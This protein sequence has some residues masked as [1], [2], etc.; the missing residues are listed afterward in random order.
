[1]ADKFSCGERHI[2]QDCGEPW[3]SATSLREERDAMQSRAEAAESDMA[4][5]T[6][7]LAEAR[8][9]LQG[10]KDVWIAHGEQIA[11]YGLPAQIAIEGAIEKAENLLAAEAQ[12]EERENG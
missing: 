5:A 12:G 6:R 8:E 2:C 10:F 11:A 3:E 4:E 1:M 9:A 7:K